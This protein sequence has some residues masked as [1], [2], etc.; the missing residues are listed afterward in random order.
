[1]TRPGPAAFNAQR[2]IE[3]PADEG[4]Y[5][6]EARRR[7]GDL[8]FCRH[9]DLHTCVFPS[10]SGVEEEVAHA[11]GVSSCCSQET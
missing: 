2:A 6:I 9:H 4:Q 8:F 7:D 3:S 11:R 5:D 10:F 1:M